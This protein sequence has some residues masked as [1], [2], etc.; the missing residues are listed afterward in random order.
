[1]PEPSQPPGRLA[2]RELEQNQQEHQEA[3]STTTVGSGI[4]LET[5]EEALRLDRASI[6]VPSEV[7]KRLAS[8]IRREPRPVRAWW[9][10]WFG[11]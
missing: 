1:M 5:P 11:S 2:H 3:P 8:S 4:T 9:R 7:E 6:G 10:R